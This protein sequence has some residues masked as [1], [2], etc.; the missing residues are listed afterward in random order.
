MK[1]LLDTDGGQYHHHR[2][3]CESRFI[4]VTDKIICDNYSLGDIKSRSLLQN[5][6]SCAELEEL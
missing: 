3:S 4:K 2:T 5:G 6:L 1:N